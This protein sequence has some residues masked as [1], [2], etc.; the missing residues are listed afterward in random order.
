MHVALGLYCNRQGNTLQEDGK[1]MYIEQEKTGG[2]II[3]NYKFAERIV[4]GESKKEN[5]DVG[6]GIKQETGG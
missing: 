5:L 2:E 6:T 1:T 3:W 4:K